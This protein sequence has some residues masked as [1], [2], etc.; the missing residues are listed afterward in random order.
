MLAANLDFLQLAQGAQP[1]VEDRLG[2]HIGEHEAPNQFG[3]RLVLLAD[4]ANHLVQVEIGDEIA[5]QHFQPVLDLAQPMFGAALQHH[6]AVRQ[7]FGQ[8]LGQAQHH[9]HLPTAEHVHVQRDA[10]FEV[11]EAEKL[12][13]QHQRIDGAGARFQHQPHILG[14]FVP[15]IGEQRQPLGFQKL[16]DL[17]DQP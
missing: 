10:R 7:P 12:L 15:D 13:H 14:Q 11:G 5:F 8:R 16:G 9:R 17:L 1:H 4:D 6:L 2:L 3:L